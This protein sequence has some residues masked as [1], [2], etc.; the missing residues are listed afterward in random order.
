MAQPNDLPRPLDGVRIVDL[1]S[2][3]FGPMATQ[4]LAEMGAEV[5]KVEPPEGDVIRNVEPMRSRGMGAVFMNS[6]RGKK[7]VALDLKSDAGREALARLVATADVFVHSMRGQAA[8]KLGIDYDSVTAIKPDLVYCFACG[9]AS[10]GPNAQLPAYDDI[11]QAA[12]GVAG[13]TRDKDG[14]PQLIRTILADKVAA[15]YLTNALMAAVMTL[16][17]TG[18]GQYVEVPMFE[19]LAHFMLVEHLAAA[20]FEPAMGPA[21]YKRVLAT[22]RQTYPTRDSYIAMLPY[23][24]A[25]WRR[26]LELVGE[27]DLAAEP[28]VS[29]AAARSARIGELYDLIAR[30]TPERTTAEWIEA[31]RG[32]D[33]PAAAVSTL[34]DLL[35]DPQLQASGLFESYDHPTEGKLKGTRPPVQG[36]WAPLPEVPRAPAL[37]EH[38]REILGELGYDTAE[39]DELAGPQD[40]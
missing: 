23:T 16:K 33:I 35:V 20:T 14:M 13:T 32:I 5:I 36:G 34:D 15:L 9:Y 3:I 8:K 21:G 4:M 38:T 39:I 40:N 25:Q 31:L 6:N 12:S 18:R 29:D 24:T 28:W 22:S 19:C 37:G 2:I 17:Q 30:K 26:F 1:T 10:S 7:D 27:N 11:I